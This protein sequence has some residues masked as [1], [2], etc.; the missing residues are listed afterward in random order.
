MAQR[1]ERMRKFSALSLLVLF[2]CYLGYV[3]VH[4]ASEVHIH[5]PEAVHQHDH[6]HGED[7]VHSHPEQPLDETDH[8]PHSYSDHEIFFVKTKIHSTLLSLDLH[9]CPWL[10]TELLLDDFLILNF[11]DSFLTPPSIGPPQP[12]LP[13][14]PPVI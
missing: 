3:P 2:L 6:E 11:E 14:G 4:L 5:H 10:E 1:L 9:I 8:Q 12:V 13:R 7:N